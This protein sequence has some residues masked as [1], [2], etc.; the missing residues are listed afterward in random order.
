MKSVEEIQVPNEMHEW[1]NQQR[2]QVQLNAKAMHIL[3]CAL[4]PEEFAKV[5]SC[6]NARRFGTSL[7]L[8]MKAQMR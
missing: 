4:G 5:S 2:K 3:L 7:K 1:N 6:D 8:S